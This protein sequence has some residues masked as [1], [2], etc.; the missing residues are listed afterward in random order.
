[1]EFEGGRGGG[2]NVTGLLSR[3]RTAAERGANP[4]AVAQDARLTL[5]F[6]HPLGDWF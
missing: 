3:A 2:F 5:Y 6:S 4:C 1:M